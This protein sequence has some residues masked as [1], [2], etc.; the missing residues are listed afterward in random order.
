LSKSGNT[1]FI[2]KLDSNCR[3]FFQ[4][5]VNSQLVLPQGG[6]ILRMVS[7]DRQS[8]LWEKDVHVFVRKRNE[9]ENKQER[10]YREKV[11]GKT[12]F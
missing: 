1:D 6:S 11:K 4:Q 7:Q 5:P 8:F 12:A 9:K 10:I 2:L 3:G